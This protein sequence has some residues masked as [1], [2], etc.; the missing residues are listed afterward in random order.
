MRAYEKLKVD[1]ARKPIL[2]L[3]L[4]PEMKMNGTKFS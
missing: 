2:F 4:L 3:V 1:E